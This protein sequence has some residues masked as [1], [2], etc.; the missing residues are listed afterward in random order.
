MTS[1]R[2]STTLTAVAATALLTLA[3]FGPAHAAPVTYSATVAYGEQIP[4]LRAAPRSLTTW[5]PTHT[6]SP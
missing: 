4:R 1:R 2:L 6:A 3:A 5:D